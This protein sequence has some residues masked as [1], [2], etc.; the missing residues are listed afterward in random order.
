MIDKMKKEQKKRRT[1]Q[2]LL[3]HV[4]NN[5]RE[6][7]IIILI[8]LVGI[9]LGIIFINNMSQKGTEEISDYLHGFV[10]SLKNNYTIDKGALL[11]QSIKSNMILG[12][13]LWFV[14]STVIGM[15]MVYGIIGFRGFC[16]GYTVSSIMASLGTGSGVVFVLS[17]ILLQN[18]LFIPCVLALAVSGMKL[19][20]S[21]MKDRRRENI[22]IEIIRHTLFSLLVLVVLLL[23][24]VI[25]VYVSTN[26]LM[27]CIKYV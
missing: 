14:G 11:M 20:Q 12:V 23:S 8:F 4:K 3:E 7:A 24:S 26:L 15:P 6:Y 27:I 5:L 10:D 13:V 21:I 22:K 1:K 16:L 19:Y 17:T 18:I 9:L 25:E 2:I